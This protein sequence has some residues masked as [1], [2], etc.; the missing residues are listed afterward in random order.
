MKVLEYIHQ[1]GFGVLY[2]E[3]VELVGPYEERDG[4]LHVRDHWDGK[5]FAAP[6]RHFREI[7]PLTNRCIC[8]TCWDARK[9]LKGHSDNPQRSTP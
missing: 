7:D 2:G 3:H 8:D 6:E 4:W 1:F 9:A 5:E